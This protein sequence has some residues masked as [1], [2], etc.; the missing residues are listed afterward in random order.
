MGRRVA[1]LINTYQPT[2]SFHVSFDAARLVSGVYMYRLSTP[3]KSIMR[4]MTL[5]K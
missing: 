4:Q 1:T 2:G 3:K 5:L